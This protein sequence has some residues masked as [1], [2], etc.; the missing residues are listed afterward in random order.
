MTPH[1]CGLLVGWN[2]F[3]WLLE[4]RRLNVSEHSKHY[5]FWPCRFAVF[6]ASTASV[7]DSENAFDQR[8]RMCQE[9]LAPS[10]EKLVD[11][12]DDTLCGI[13]SSDDYFPPFN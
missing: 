8:A 2:L 3:E 6:F 4:L 10:T 7:C 12:V 5:A 11:V 9:L 1:L 13:C